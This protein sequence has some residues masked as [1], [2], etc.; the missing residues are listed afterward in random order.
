MALTNTAPFVVTNMPFSRGSLWQLVQPSLVTVQPLVRRS[1]LCSVETS[2]WTF[3]NS[4]SKS[5]SLSWLMLG[6]LYPLPQVLTYRQYHVK[7]S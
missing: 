1:V 2:L 3:W 6:D 7:N 5:P 4:A